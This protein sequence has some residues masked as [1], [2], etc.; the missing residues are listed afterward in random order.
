MSLPTDPQPRTRPPLLVAIAGGSGAGKTTLARWLTDSLHPIAVSLIPLDNYY[1]DLSHKPPADRA[2]TNF[3]AP[4]AIEWERLHSD[5]GLLLEGRSARIPCYDF[6]THTR[7]EQTEERQPAD[8]LL[9]EG[10]FALS[11]AWVRDRAAVRVF[12][13]A[14][15]ETCLARRLDRDVRE[16]GRTPG[17]VRRRF[18]EHVW[19]M[20]TRHVEPTREAADWILPGEG[21]GKTWRQLSAAIR[22][23]WAAA[24]RSAGP[25]T[26]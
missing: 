17:E 4:E 19:P 2:Q 16:R 6:H 15:A 10:L 13:E 24:E 9:L 3:D 8:V 21:D 20:F 23:Q 5:L 22:E 12:V 25:C 1:R 14:A 18:Q 7:L 26:R 11:D